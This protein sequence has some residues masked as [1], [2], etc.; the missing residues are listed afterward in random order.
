MLRDRARVP[1]GS[2]QDASCPSYASWQSLDLAET[3]GDSPYPAVIPLQ[4][5]A[6]VPTPLPGRWG[7]AKSVAAAKVLAVE[8]SSSC[9]TAC[10][11]PK[12]PRRLSV[13]FSAPI[14]HSERAPCNY[15]LYQ[16]L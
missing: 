7:Q 14:A 4:V 8:R 13:V 2:A 6:A 15:P 12:T 9:S 10:E 5:T 11:A 3:G 16:R 1:L